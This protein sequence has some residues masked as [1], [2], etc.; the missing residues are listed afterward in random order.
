MP[1]F[2]LLRKSSIYLLGIY[3]YSGNQ[4]HIKTYLIKFK[5]P[6]SLNFANMPL[7]ILLRKPNIYLLGFHIYSGKYIHFKTY[8][9]KFKLI[10]IFIKFT[11]IHIF[12]IY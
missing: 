11:S 7:F 2:I 1:L 6:F 12:S 5:F 8:L 9:I 3:V 10:S 4:I